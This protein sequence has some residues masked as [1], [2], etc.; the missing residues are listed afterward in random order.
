MAATEGI[1]RLTG[2]ENWKD[3]NTRFINEAKYK[4]IWDLISPESKTKGQFQERPVEPAVANYPKQK[5]S[6]ASGTRAS[7]SDTARATPLP[8]PAEQDGK[9]TTVFE[10][11]TAGREQYRQ[12][13]AI[14]QF[15][16]RRYN[17]ER[18]QVSHIATW[19]STTVDNEIYKATCE[20][21][22]T[23][24]KWYAKL[25]LRAG[26]SPREER[27]QIRNLKEEN[28]PRTVAKGAFAVSFAGRSSDQEEGGETKPT[29]RR[30]SPPP[31]SKRRYTGGMASGCPA[32]DGK[33]TLED[34]WSVRPEI[35]PAY[36]KPAKAAEIRARERMKHDSELRQMVEQLKKR[37]KKEGSSAS[38]STRERSVQFV[39]EGS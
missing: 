28:K 11:T 1:P 18:D 37:V 22:D 8:E 35:R 39:E 33:H 36:K 34:C 21:D 29:Q 17:D 15:N 27:K 4:R 38:S 5:T 12:D 6:Q 24:D 10:L 26:I 23:L 16:W 31:R 3:W 13:M 9:P 30:V 20:P 32:C 19:I 2:P 7:S 25:K 14:F